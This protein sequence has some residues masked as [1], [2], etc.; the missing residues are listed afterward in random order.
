M[1]PDEQDAAYLLDMLHHARGI[2]RAVDT[3]THDD[4]LDDEDLR[5]LVERR[6]L[7]IGEAAH[8]VSQEFKDGH[9][10]IPW[11]KIVG[12]RNILAHAYGEIDDEIMWD[13]ATISV[14]ELVR[15]LETVLPASSQG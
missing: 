5:L 12:Q 7:I 1:P 13:A 9:P 8:H 14:P 6:V 3:R 2:L 10:Q 11:H 15:F 4:Y